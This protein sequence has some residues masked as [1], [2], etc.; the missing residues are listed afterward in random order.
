MHR[1]LFP[2]QIL[3]EAAEKATRAPHGNGNCSRGPPANHAKCRHSYRSEDEELRNA[4]APA[5]AA[6]VVTV[7]VVLGARHRPRVVKSCQEFGVS[8]CCSQT[9]AGQCG[10]HKRIQPTIK[11]VLPTQG[12]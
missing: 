6:V 11:P 10:K 1:P 5:Q 12:T 7:G 2:R 3:A 9:R 4:T 8:K